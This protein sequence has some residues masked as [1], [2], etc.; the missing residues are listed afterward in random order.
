VIAVRRAEAVAR[1]AERRAAGDTVPDECDRAFIVTRAEAAELLTSEL[2]PPSIYT[3]DSGVLNMPEL[4]AI[5]AGLRRIP[6]VFWQVERP[7]LRI[8]SDLRYN[9]V[10]GASASV[11]VGI[12]FGRL[13]ADAELGMGT[14]DRRLRGELGITRPGSALHSRAAGYLRLA[15]V[16]AASRPF[17]L[18]SSLNALLLGRDEHEYFRTAG[19]EL[20]AA[21]GDARM[22]WYDVRLFAERQSAATKHTDFSVPHM[23]DDDRLFRDNF[24]ADA[25]DQLG[26]TARLRISSG[27]N[28]RAFRGAAELELHGETGDYTF[29][30]PALRLQSSLP[31]GPFALTTQLA[32]G[33]S[34][35]GAPAQR[36]WLLGGS[37]TLRGYPFATVRG[38]AFWRGRAELGFGGAA[39]RLSVFGDIG[40]AG[41]RRD[42]FDARPLRSAGVGIS[43]LDGLLRLDLA[44]PLDGGRWRVHAHFERTP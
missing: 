44:R 11:G 3:T 38:E 2:L 6:S 15:S 43:V 31:L 16:D 20:I 26:A 37:A 32:G 33:S 35:G 7:A 42:L 13:T 40:Y 12:D 17:S 28:P 27:L 25:A 39:A 14:G 10:E 8:P 36:D 1:R 23:I 4:E 24:A 41:D 18:G 29:V 30:R 9:R 19:A 5:A 21:P 22:Q 34:F